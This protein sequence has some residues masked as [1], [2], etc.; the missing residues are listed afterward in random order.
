M[1]GLLLKD[2][3]MMRSY[4][5]AF[6]VIVAVFLAGAAADS[7]LFFIVYPL[8]MIGMLPLTLI[9]YDERE[10]WDIYSG[11]LPYTREQ[12]VRGKY[13]IGLVGVLAVLALTAAVQAVKMGISGS[14]S[15]KELLFL[16]LPLFGGG[17]LCPIFTLPLIY[18]FGAEKGRII[19]IGSVMVFCAVGALLMELNQVA[20]SFIKVIMGIPEVVVCGVLP[21]AALVMYGV[22]YLIS[23]KI[24]KNREV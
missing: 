1:K 17:M 9:T 7:N 3:Y 4:C 24:Y 18:K 10:K 11:T 22:S 12:L 5:R 21:I 8:V 19:Y 23:V 13:L 6:L 15:G 16:L 14:F 2:F 20:A